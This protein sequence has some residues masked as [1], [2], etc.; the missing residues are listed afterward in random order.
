MNASEA[1]TIEFKNTLSREN[2]CSQEPVV[3]KSIHSSSENRYVPFLTGVGREERNRLHPYGVL[4][5]ETRK[6]G[7]CKRDDRPKKNKIKG[8]S[9][10]ARIAFGMWS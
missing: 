10:Q 7:G 5:M 1:G 3:S 2:A 8:R 9:L 6:R 4:R